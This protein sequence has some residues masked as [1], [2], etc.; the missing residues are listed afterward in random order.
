MSHVDKEILEGPAKP[1]S[2]PEYPPIRVSSSAK[3]TKNSLQV[4][5]YL[6]YLAFYIFMFVTNEQ[7]F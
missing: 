3:E 2:V 4:T 6:N 1:N 5:L 7:R